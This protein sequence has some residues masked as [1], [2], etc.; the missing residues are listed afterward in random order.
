[1]IAKP[2]LLVFAFLLVNGGSVLLIRDWW[3]NHKNTDMWPFTGAENLVIAWPIALTVYFDCRVA[4][5][6]AGPAL[7]AC[8]GG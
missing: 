7:R 4:I 2:I 6:Y 3:I 5:G 1:M 8:F